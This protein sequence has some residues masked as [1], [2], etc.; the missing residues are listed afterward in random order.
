MRALRSAVLLLGVL[1]ATAS[2]A[3]WFETTDAIMGTRIHAEVWHDDAATAAELLDAVLA[4]MRRIDATYSPYIDD[5]E[6]SRLNRD[7]P[8]GWVATTPEMIDLLQKSAEVSRLT[9]GAFDITY[10]SVG[11][12][13]DYRKGERPDAS[14]LTAGLE[15][16]NWEFVEIDEPHGRVRF[17]HPLVYVDL[18]GIAK[19]YA[20]DRCIELLQKAG[21]TQASVSAGG[22]S[23]IIGDRNGEPWTVGVRDPRNEAAMAVLLPLVDTAVS[24]SG[25]YERFFEEDGIRYHHILDPRTGDSARQSWSVTILGPDATFTDA[26]STSVFVLGPDA[27]LALID[28][29]PGIDAIIIDATGKLRYSAD[30]AEAAGLGKP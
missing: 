6:L 26:L 7:A 25:D 4:E 1:L 27:G 11:R 19:G 12:Y 13:Y 9:Q 15:A 17:S 2:H 14:E 10:A 5:S 24:T 20:V 23:R 28:R 29:L 8:K 18:G 16:I 21:V 22:D 30:L 3:E